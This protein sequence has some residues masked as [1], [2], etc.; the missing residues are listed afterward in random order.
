MSAALPR[1]RPVRDAG[2]DV[3]DVL[4][5]PA[6][7]SADVGVL[8]GVGGR[9]SAEEARGDLDVG[10][11]LF[12]GVE[13]VVRE[14]GE[15]GHGRGA[16]LG[17]GHFMSSLVRASGGTFSASA[18]RRTVSGVAPRSPRSSRERYGLLRPVLRSSSRRPQAWAVLRARIATPLGFIHAYVRHSIGMTQALRRLRLTLD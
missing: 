4:G 6:R 8:D 10:G 14:R 16:V 7:E 18:M 13:L 12:G 11:G 2:D 1:S 5:A 15:F 17:D 3:A 9:A